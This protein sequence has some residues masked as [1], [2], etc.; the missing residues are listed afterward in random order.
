MLL[1]CL[2]ILAVDFRIF[3]RRFAKTET[4]GISLMDIGVGTFIVS[5]AVTSRYARGQ[6]P[7]RI[8]KSNEI[9]DYE[10][11]R[12]KEG[13]EK[14]SNDDNNSDGNREQNDDEKKKSKNGNFNL[15]TNIKK[16]INVIYLSQAQ[17]WKRFSVLFLGIGR[18]VS[19]KV[20]NYPE[21]V[22]EYG[23]HWNFFVTLF[24][25]WQITDI[26]HRIFS[27]R[28]LPSLSIGCLLLYQFALSKTDLT[29]FIF[30]ASRKNFFYANREGFLSLCGYVPMYL[31]IE[32]FAYHFFY[33]CENYGEDYTENENEIKNGTND[34][35]ENEI[36]YNSDDDKKCKSE[37]KNSHSGDFSSENQ[38]NDGTNYGTDDNDNDDNDDNNDATDSGNNN[39]NNNNKIINSTMNSNY[40]S[41]GETV[42]MN[43]NLDTIRPLKTNLKII[44][45]F[46]T[47][48]EQNPEQKESLL[49]SFLFNMSNKSNFF[50][51]SL[52]SP[53]SV[54][55]TTSNTTSYT[56]SNTTS[57]KSNKKDYIKDRIGCRKKRVFFRQLFIISVVLWLAWLSSTSVQQTSR[58]LANLAFV[59]LVLA[60]SFTLILLIALAD[61]IG[62][63]V[64]HY[65]G[66]KLN[67]QNNDECSTNNLVNKNCNNEEVKNSL[68]G[69]NGDNYDG[70]NNSNINKNN[71]DNYIDDNANKNNENRH[72]I[73]SAPI[74]LPVA[75]LEYLNTYQLP[76]FLVANVF[77]GVVNMS[78]KT[79]YVSHLV[80]FFILCIYS[81]GF[82]GAAW[83]LYKSFKKA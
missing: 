58:R 1:T 57:G 60:I 4:F 27:R 45:K 42:K 54:S 63:L 73:K 9:G 80:A 56:T 10:Q 43:E 40:L 50:T 26:I 79:I 59:S 76:V 21:N 18:M 55:A 8:L 28:V 31:L 82:T 12:E 74:P 52:S 46:D 77:T 48:R 23:V 83:L 49:F 22:S 13:G 2:A 17:N 71:D 3:P 14:R 37:F 53:M 19:L 6:Y 36:F 72:D 47:R 68:G 38:D 15:F 7:P 44:T 5:S 25:I 81:T 70:N 75:T 62:D 29:D 32:T 11:T 33:K 20:L 24:C 16:I 65:K 34:I 39:D 64:L 51:T 30:A 35:D 41:I 61:S 69:N 66:S 67:V 78:I